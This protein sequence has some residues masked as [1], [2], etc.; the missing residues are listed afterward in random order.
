MT[1]GQYNAE[2]DQA[3]EDSKNWLMINSTNHKWTF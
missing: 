1:M 2:I 3:M